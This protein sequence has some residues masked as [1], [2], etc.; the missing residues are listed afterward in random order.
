MTEEKF[1][2][3]SNHLD[4]ALNKRDKIANAFNMIEKTS[5]SIGFGIQFFDES[6]FS[7]YCASYE[8]FLDQ[9]E[10][11][12]RALA[13]ASSNVDGLIKKLKDNYKKTN[14]EVLKVKVVAENSDVEKIS[15]NS[16]YKLTYKKVFAVEE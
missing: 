16:R 2:D 8:N 9:S 3:E 6:S 4:N 15:L 1:K 7:I 5:P 11:K 14:N 10:R 13:E 12:T